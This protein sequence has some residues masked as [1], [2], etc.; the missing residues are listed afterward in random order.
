[1]SRVTIRDVAAAAG[2]SAWSVCATLGP[3]GR[4]GVSDEM[5]QR[6]LAAAEAVGYS[7]PPADTFRQRSVCDA[8][9]LTTRQADYWSTIGLIP[10]EVYGHDRYYDRDSVRMAAVIKAL[11]DEGGM[12]FPAIRRMVEAVWDWGSVPAVLVM[13]GDGYVRPADDVVQAVVEVMPQVLAVSGAKVATVL[14]VATVTGP[15]LAKLD[16]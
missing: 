7:R 1:M 8:V 16:T 11:V 2:C 13:G 4:R 14:D 12:R 3:R 10:S 9:G 6:V 5:A 15:A